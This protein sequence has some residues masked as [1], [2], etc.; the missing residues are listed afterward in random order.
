[1][2]SASAITNDLGWGWHWNG[3]LMGG[4]GVQGEYR[5]GFIQ[6]V[7]YR[8]HSG[9]F[10]SQSWPVTHEP[11]SS[12]TPPTKKREGAIA[13]EMSDFILACHGDV[14]ATMKVGQDRRRLTFDRFKPSPWPPPNKTCNVIL[15]GCHWVTEVT[16]AS[17]CQSQSNILNWVQSLG[18]RYM[19][20][21]V[22][23]L[24]GLN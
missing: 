9:Q 21:W 15:D 17:Q 2:E 6:E 4:G 8:G 20:V 19:S 10:A 3:W 12:S 24:V 16:A 1:M 13:C 5:I 22:C 14:S 11:S 23:K 7:I 18:I